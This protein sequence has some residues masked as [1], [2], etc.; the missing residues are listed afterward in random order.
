MGPGRPANCTN[1]AD[2]R[3]AIY[4]NK[5]DAYRPSQKRVFWNFEGHKEEQ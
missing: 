2:S 4:I 3:E 5:M 1:L